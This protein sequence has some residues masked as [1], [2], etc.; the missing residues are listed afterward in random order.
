MT[1]RSCE[2]SRVEVPEPADRLLMSSSTCAWIVTS[3]AVVGTS[4][5]SSRGLMATAIA[6]I[7]RWRMPPDSS[8]G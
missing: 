8:W 6:A 5:M 2:I 7:T 3:S 1:P 4:A